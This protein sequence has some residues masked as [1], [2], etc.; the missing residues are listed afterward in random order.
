MSYVM[1]FISLCKTSFCICAETLSFCHL[2][3]NLFFPLCKISYFVSTA[4]RGHME[5]IYFFLKG[6]N[7]LFLHFLH[8]AFPFNIFCGSA[9]IFVWQ[10]LQTK[11]FLKS[12]YC[13]SGII[14]IVSL[15]S[16]RFC[17]RC[18]SIKNC[19]LC[20]SIYLNHYI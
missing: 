17:T 1:K 20:S 4:K 10:L 8:F 7:A 5:E 11:T 16:T 13:A 18:K 3:V 6:L 9:L 2:F 14:A 12:L 15:N 19:S